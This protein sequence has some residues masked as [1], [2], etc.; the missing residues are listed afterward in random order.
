MSLNLN[1]TI[2]MSVP[3]ALMMSDIAPQSPTRTLMV[4]VEEQ[5]DVLITEDGALK[6]LRD[7]VGE[8]SPRDAGTGP[9]EEGSLMPAR[10]LLN[11]EIK[12]RYAVRTLPRHRS[13]YIPAT[14][15]RFWEKKRKSLCQDAPNG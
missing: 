3:C 6:H 14:H 5:E 11:L 10:Q 13:E 9:P 8:K 2:R 15:T 1:P 12:E 7:C 4:I